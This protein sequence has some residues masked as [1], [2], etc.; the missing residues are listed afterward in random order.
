MMLALF[1][2]LFCLS[3]FRKYL[4]LFFTFL[5]IHTEY[6]RRGESNRIEYITLWLAQ[7]PAQ[8]GSGHPRPELQGT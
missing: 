3:F 5:S 1:F 6:L 2:F 7:C 4:V 8:E